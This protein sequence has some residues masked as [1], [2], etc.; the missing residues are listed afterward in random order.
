MSLSKVLAMD[1]SAPLIPSNCL[2][3][4]KGALADQAGKTGWMVN[5]SSR[6]HLVSLHRF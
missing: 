1:H 3:V 4:H 5:L 2:A 6:F